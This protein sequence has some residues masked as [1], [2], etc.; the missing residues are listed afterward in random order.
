M[1]SSPL[2]FSP[3]LSSRSPSHRPTRKPDT[4]STPQ[5]VKGP[6]ASERIN[7]NKRNTCGSTSLMQDLDACT[8]MA[9]CWTAPPPPRRAVPRGPSLP[10]PPALCSFP[11]ARSGRVVTEA[12][13]FERKLLNDVCLTRKLRPSQVRNCPIR[14]EQSP[15]LKWC[16]TLL[17]LPGFRGISCPSFAFAFA[18]ILKSVLPLALFPFSD[19]SFLPTRHLLFIPAPARGGCDLPPGSLVACKK[20]KLSVMLMCYARVGMSALSLHPPPIHTFDPW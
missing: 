11:R 1:L 2:L 6:R 18:C 17:A 13:S 5:S 19:A 12:C 16:S 3:L 8:H 15:S 7:T 4:K 20:C 14:S 10:R 9:I